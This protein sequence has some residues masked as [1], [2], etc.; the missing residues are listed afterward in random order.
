MKINEN[1]I[2]KIYEE[3]GDYIDTY[4]IKYPNDMEI[5]PIHYKI[6]NIWK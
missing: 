4:M 5:Q 1:N 6:F 2:E 3:C